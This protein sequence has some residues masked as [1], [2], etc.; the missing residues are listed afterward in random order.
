MYMK[1]Y[2]TSLEKGHSLYNKDF[3]II[4]SVMAISQVSIIF[5]S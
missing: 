5:L 3:Q 4:E 1:P 2:E